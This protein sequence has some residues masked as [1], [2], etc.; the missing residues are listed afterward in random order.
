VIEMKLVN[1]AKHTPSKM[2]VKNISISN[3]NNHTILL[4]FFL[5][6]PEILGFSIVNLKSELIYKMRETSFS[7]GRHNLSI[8]QPVS[9]GIYFLKIKTARF[10]VT[11][12]ILIFSH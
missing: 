11:R 5:D 12:K 9:P 8:S 1:I 4:S 10:G 2:P 6:Q 3:H 7:S